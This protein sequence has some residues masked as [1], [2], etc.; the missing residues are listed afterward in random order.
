MWHAEENAGV[1]GKIVQRHAAVPVVVAD[2]AILPKFAAGGKQR[3]DEAV[4]R[5]V[6]KQRLFHPQLIRDA[7]IPTASVI[8]LEAQNVL[9]NWKK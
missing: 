6:F 7:G 1:V 8:F 3:G 4:K 2:R 9:P 5:H